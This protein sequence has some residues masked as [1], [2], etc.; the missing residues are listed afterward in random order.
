MK[1][2]AACYFA[3]SVKYASR[4]LFPRRI[5]LFLVHDTLV[6]IGNGTISDWSQGACGHRI[7]ENV[8]RA[9][10]SPDGQWIF[11][12]TNNRTLEICRADTRESLQI[13][14]SLNLEMPIAIFILLA[15]N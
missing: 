12:I 15:F 7:M 10:F 11:C 9:E 13:T 1:I 6:N 14:S 5:M 3:L 8:C 2:L 4:Y